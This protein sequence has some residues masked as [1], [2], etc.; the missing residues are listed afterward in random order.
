VL[1]TRRKDS[2]YSSAC[3]GRRRGCSGG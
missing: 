2:N 3:S 1:I